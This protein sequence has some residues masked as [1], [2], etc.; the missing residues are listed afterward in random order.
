MILPG[1]PHE[2]K[3]MFTRQCLPRLQRDRAAAGDPHPGAAHLRHVGIGSRSDHL[4]HLQAVREPGHH[5]ARAQRRHAGASARA[6][7]DRSAKRWRCWPKSAARSTPRWATGSTRATA[8]R[9][10]PWSGK[11]L[12]GAHATLAVAESATGGGLADRITSVPG[13]SAYFLGGFVTYTQRM[14]TELLGVPAEILEQ[15]GA[16]S[17]ETAEAMAIGARA[18]RARPGRSRSPAMPGPTTDG[19]EAPVGM[20]HVGIERARRDRD[21]CTGTGPP[22]TARACG[23]SPPRWRSISYT[24]N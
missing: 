21:V 7:R 23:R 20:V 8:I 6:L 4:A 19:D 13:S 16:V 12:A 22:A 9:W 17:T 11:K 18:A 1:P 10:K 3:S 15:F 14:K 5:R 24:G 2:L